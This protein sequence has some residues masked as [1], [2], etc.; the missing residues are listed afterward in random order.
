MTGGGMENGEWGNEQ[1][2]DYFRSGDR[3]TDSIVFS[4]RVAGLATDGSVAITSPA[5]LHSDASITFAQGELLGSAD[6]CI[7]CMAGRYSAYLNQLSVN[8]SAIAG[9]TRFQESMCYPPF[10][11]SLII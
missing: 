11:A 4:A 3:A 8:A 9:A 1:G 5:F 6:Q 2:P 10:R 7:Q